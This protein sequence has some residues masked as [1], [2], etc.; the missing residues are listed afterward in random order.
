MGKYQLLTRYLEKLADDSW[1]AD[2]QSVERI[3]GFPLPGSAH[4][5]Q[6]WWAN[7]TG[8]GH[9]QTRG[10]QDAGFETRNL[11]LAEKRVRFD[12]VSRKAREHDGIVS[13]PS[14]LLAQA[15][16]MTGITDRAALVAEAFGALIQR[17]AASYLASLGGIMADA[18][19][20]PRRRP[21]S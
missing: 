17:E 11:N 4:D 13:P 7:Q 18:E 14:E 20:A 8:G 2:F 15:M 1:E 21:G 5:H 19:A 16:A 9:T 3:L 12:R 10:W 6:A